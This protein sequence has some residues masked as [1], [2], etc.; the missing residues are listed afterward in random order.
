VWV[1]DFI[2]QMEQAYAAADIVISRAGAMAIAEICLIAK[3]AVFVP[4][5]FAAEDHQ[6]VNAE[7][8]VSKSAG[9]MIKDHEAKD[10]LVPAIMALAANEIKQN[11]LKRNIA[12]LGVADAD[13]VIANEILKLI[14]Q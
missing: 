1:N 14:K 11:E 12:K 6:T 5:P 2:Q 10:D 7:H 8:L 4:F 13:T 9:L 3:P